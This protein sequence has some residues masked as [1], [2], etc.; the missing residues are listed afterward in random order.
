MIILR[1]EKVSKAITWK[2]LFKTSRFRSNAQMDGD[3]LT[4]AHSATY[5]SIA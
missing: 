1:A 5:E 2:L 4:P 3:D